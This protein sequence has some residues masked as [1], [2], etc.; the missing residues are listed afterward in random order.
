MYEVNERGVPELLNV[1]SKQLLMM[2]AGASGHVTPMR[3]QR[4]MGP[5][6]VHFHLG[7]P[8]EHATQQQIATRVERVQR[9]AAARNG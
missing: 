4:A 5:T 7:A 9:R 2:P 6:T 1:G 3:S 8:T